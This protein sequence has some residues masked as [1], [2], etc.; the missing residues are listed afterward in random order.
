MKTIYQKDLIMYKGKK[1]ILMFGFVIVTVVTVTELN[2]VDSETQITEKSHA[3]D[4][5]DI[6]FINMQD[7]MIASAQGKR[8]QK[9]V[10]TQ[11]IK[12]AELAQK[13]QQHMMQ[14]KGDLES[15]APMLSPEA[16]RKMEK[17][18]ADL[19]RDYR[20]KLEDWK[21]DLQGLMQKETTT[22]MENIASAAE[23]LAQN[24][25]KAVVIDIQTG[26]V[27]YIRED[28]DKTADLVT[29]LDNRDKQLQAQQA[30]QQ[31]KKI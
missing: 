9:V 20:I 18:L 15:Q 26:R 27:V 30:A 5:S 16:R 11:E 23:Q 24:N 29:I 8:A 13:E 7:A 4:D 19:E 21:Y 14:V 17:D 3:I 1:A 22:M 25:D 2:K 28:K 10:E 6:I 12:Y 31:N